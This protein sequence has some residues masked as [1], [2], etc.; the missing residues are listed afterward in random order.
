[1]NITADGSSRKKR[2]MAEDI[3]LFAAMKLMPRLRDRLCIDINLIPRLSEKDSVAGDCIW[4]D[5]RTRPREFTIR[6][7]SS[8]GMQLMLETVAHE[9]VHVKQ[10]ARGELQDV[11]SDINICKWQGSIV[12]CSTVDYYDLPWEIEAHGRER[13]LF[14]RWFEQCRWKNCKWAQY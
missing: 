2:E 3:A 1:M 5:N 7:D 6:I 12:N 13:G 11:S 9:I 14:I 10:F 4:E 8:Q